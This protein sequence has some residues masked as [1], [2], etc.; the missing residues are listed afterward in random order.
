MHQT[1]DGDDNGVEQTKLDGFVQRMPKW[2]RDGL[3]EYIMNWVIATDQVCRF[4][5]CKCMSISLTPNQAFEGVDHPTF[6]AML[7]YQRPSML[8]LDIPHR[9]LVSEDVMHKAD[10][11]QFCIGQHFKVS[12]IPS[13]S[14]DNANVLFENIASEVLLTFDLWTSRSYDPYLGITAHYIDTPAD[15]H[16]EWELKTV[17][18]GYTVVEG[19]HSGANIA[20]HIIQVLDKYGLREKVDIYVIL[21]ATMLIYTSEH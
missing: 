19:N 1:D 18:L 12:W 11:V 8:E 14:S 5:L 4:M 16:S 17:T 21:G 13:K 10:L 3:K 20:A 9:T 2:T 15:R 6:R 7:R